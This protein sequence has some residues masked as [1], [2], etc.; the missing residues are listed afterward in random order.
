[1]HSNAPSEDLLY[2]S[3]TVCFV[4]SHTAKVSLRTC[5]EKRICSRSSFGR[6]HFNRRL[7][8]S[9]ADY[10]NLWPL[11]VPLWKPIRGIYFTIP[12]CFKIIS[13][14]LSKPDQYVSQTGFISQFLTVHTSVICHAIRQFKIA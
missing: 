6:N 13:I 5:F 8:G 10:L 3:P 7:P 12:Q 14:F 11:I 1:M 9:S 4:C 2:P